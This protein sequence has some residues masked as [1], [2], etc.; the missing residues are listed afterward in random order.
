MMQLSRFVQQQRLSI[1]VLKGALCMLIVSATCLSTPVL[2]N[3]A[4]LKQA[5][6]FLEKRQF[7]QAQLLFKQLISNDAFV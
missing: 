4:D 3:E 5:N 7:E 2:S 1:R 6:A